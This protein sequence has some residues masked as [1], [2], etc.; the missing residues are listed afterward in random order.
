MNTA[1]TIKQVPELHFTTLTQVGVAGL[2]NTFSRLMAWAGPK[3]LLADPDFKMATVFY[4][5]FKVTTPDK[6]RMKVCL[7]TAKAIASEGDIETLTLAPQKCIVAGFEIGPDEFEKTWASLF[8]WMNE[9]GYSKADNPPFEIYHNN[10][11]EHPEKKCIVDM[12]IPIQ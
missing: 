2:Q 3:G 12:Y 5:S 8:I 4:D 10:F 9:N 11:N 7:L 6:V 1:I